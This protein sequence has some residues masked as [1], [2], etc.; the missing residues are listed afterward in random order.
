MD[1]EEY[2]SE[3]PEMVDGDE[4]YDDAPETSSY[5]NSSFERPDLQNAHRLRSTPFKEEA[6]QY[7]QNGN[8][9]PRAKRALSAFI[10]QYLSE[11]S[12]LSN[13]PD[14]NAALL[15]FD[16]AMIKMVPNYYP[17]D[18][19]NPL[20]YTIEELLRDHIKSIFT[21]ATGGDRERL[22]NMR[23]SVE[24]RQVRMDDIGKVKV[25]AEKRKSLL[26]GVI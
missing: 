16:I 17:S 23:Q 18:R 14:E 13:Y 26:D 15:D 20:L 24:S 12:L 3:E 7:I 21:R 2:E 5:F 11:M 22:L 8:L 9:Y 4:G 1:D 25:K 10:D 6:K 19:K